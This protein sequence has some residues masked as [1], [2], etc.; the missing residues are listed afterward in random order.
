MKMKVGFLLN[1]LFK[2][3][4]GFRPFVFSVWG[5]SDP[6]TFLESSLA[7]NTHNAL[8]LVACSTSTVPEHRG[9]HVRCLLTSEPNNIHFMHMPNTIYLYKLQ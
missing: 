7:L 5:L 8:A 3:G 1:F 4:L 6:V 2:L 9:T